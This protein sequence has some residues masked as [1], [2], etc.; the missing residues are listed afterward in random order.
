MVCL[1]ARPEIKRANEPQL[2]LVHSVF[3]MVV[4]VSWF[5]S[6][7]RDSC[8]EVVCEGASQGGGPGRPIA[9]AHDH[10]MNNT[11]TMKLGCVVKH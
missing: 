2:G 8:D 3:E 11:S 1:A 7:S 10:D 4:R 6:K 5:E 9:E